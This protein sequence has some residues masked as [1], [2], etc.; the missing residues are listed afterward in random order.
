MHWGLRLALVALTALGCANERPTRDVL[1][2][3]TQ[4][5]P[6]HLDP[7]FPEDALGAALGRLVYRGLMEGDP[8]TFVAR[9]AMAERIERIDSTHVRAVLRSG[10][11]FQGGSRV[12]ARDVAATYESLLNPARGSRLRSTYARVIRGV[13]ATNERTVEFELHRPDGTFESL[14]QQP[15]LPASD[16][17][18]AEIMA[19]PGSEARF[20]GAGAVR[21]TRI[22]RG[23]WEFTRVEA[24]RL[25]PSRIDFVSLHDPNT[26]AQRML[27]GGG[28]VAE[29]KPELFELFEHRSDFSVESAPS[30]GFTFLGVRCTSPGLS[31]R[32][33]RAAIAHAIDRERLRVGKL[34]SHGVASTGP[35]PPTHWA[36]EANVARYP[37]DPARARVLL[38]EAGLVD[39][40][41]PTP[42]ARWVLRVSSQRFAMTVAQAAASM[43][44]DVGIEVAVRPSELATLLSDLRQGSFDLTF[45]TVPDL[46]DPWGLSFW[47]GSASI[48]TPSNPG[49]GGNRWRFRSGA[50]DATL[51]A[52]ARSIGADARA[53][54]YRLAQQILA[55]ELPIV[56]L[57]HADVVFVASRR[58]ENLTPRGDGQLDFLLGLTRRRGMW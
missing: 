55:E 31:D 16:A 45:L 20:V 37:F 4:A 11:T 43:L 38:D 42:R 46:S 13:R 50:L 1:T 56:P 19:N 2:V 48:P 32:R 44:A 49:A 25:A 58:Y 40:P 39:P 12:T 35:I 52:G 36:Y 28:D 7:R 41:G 15:I 14:L 9:P 6:V 54:H 23:R 17:H 3:L 24:R 53:P 26:L 51:E 21:V 33:V 8:R 18:G 57:W 10:L 5:E 22:A 27:H 34:G 29:I 47:F 30:A